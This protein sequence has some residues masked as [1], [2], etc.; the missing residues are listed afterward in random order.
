[1]TL[2][3]SEQQLLACYQRLEKPLYN[4]LYRMLWQ[5]QECQD[6]LQDTFMQ[7]WQQREQLRLDGID[8]YIYTTALNLARQKLRW[9]LHWLLDSIEPWLELL[10]SSNCPE[11][12]VLA[13]QQQ[14][15][16]RRALARLSDKDR[17]VLL[18]TEYSELTLAYTAAVL[19][20]PAGTVA[21]RRARALRQLQQFLQEQPDAT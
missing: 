17:E 3:C 5:A 15:L 10:Q 13:D 11:T 20:V 4:L 14:R 8:A 18:L 19:Q 12:E 21:S 7:I 2:F 9:R 6:L 16:L 1:M